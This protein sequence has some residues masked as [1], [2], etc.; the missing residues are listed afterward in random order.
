MNSTMPAAIPPS[1]MRATSM[2]KITPAPASQTARPTAPRPRARGGGAVTRV[3]RNARAPS[4]R[5]A[6]ADLLLLAG[7]LHGFDLAEILLPQLAVLHHDFREIFV[8]YDIAG[9]GIDR[10]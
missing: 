5:R 8:H 4:A 1:S 9:S 3:R 2:P 10:D 7:V 6:G